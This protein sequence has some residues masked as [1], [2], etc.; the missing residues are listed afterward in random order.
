MDVTTE[1]YLGQFLALA[2]IIL[3]QTGVW[4]VDSRGEPPNSQIILHTANFL[5]INCILIKYY[6]TGP[7][8]PE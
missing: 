1:F 6:L 7:F 2:W 4:Y 5:G 3:V 8:S